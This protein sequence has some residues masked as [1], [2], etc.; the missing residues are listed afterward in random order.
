[1]STIRCLA[2][3]AVIVAVAPVASGQLVSVRPGRYEV[4]AQLDW[5]DARS[6][7][8]E[9]KSFDC[10]TPEQSRNLLKA[11]TKEIASE[12]NCTLTNVAKTGSTLSFDTACRVEGE[13]H[14]GRSEVTYG[15]D[16]FK[17]TVTMT[18]DGKRTTSR[19]SGKWVGPTCKDDD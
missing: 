19:S 2:I 15:V 3:C 13:V 14:T 1:M 7:F 6:R 17:A 16:W 8:K 12:A 5:V 9:I 11:F 18:L 10:I 4:V